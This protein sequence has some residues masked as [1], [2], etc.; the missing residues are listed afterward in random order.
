MNG[1]ERPVKG[2][3]DEEHGA[4]SSQ[5]M[6]ETIGVVQTLGRGFYR[7][8]INIYRAGFKWMGLGSFQQ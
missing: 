8:F 1:R 6:A 5:V 3:K 7:C 2:Y 4:S